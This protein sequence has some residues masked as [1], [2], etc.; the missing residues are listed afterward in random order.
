MINA[1]L[2][3]YK[4]SKYSMKYLVIALICILCIVPALAQDPDFVFKAGDLIDVKVPCFNSGSYCSGSAQCNLSVYYPNGSILINNG[5]ATNNGAFHNFTIQKSNTWISGTY[6]STMVCIDGA[7]NGSSSFYIQITPTGDNKVNVFYFLIIILSYGVLIFGVWKQDVTI[8]LLGAFALVF[9]GLYVLFY[10][11]DIYKNY[12][13]NGFA[14]IT[15]GVSFYVLAIASYEYL[16][17]G[18]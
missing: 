13:T 5:E 12:L 1:R 3:R 10:G 2:F 11:L 8:S 7:N 15:L 18:G 4:N 17:E 14:I 16:V 6:P 9:L